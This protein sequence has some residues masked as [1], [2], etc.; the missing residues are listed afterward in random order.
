MTIPKFLG[1]HM[2]KANP[3]KDSAL[4]EGI[5]AQE[6]I[7]IIG[8]QI[9]DHLRR[10]HGADLDVAVGIK[11]GFGN[12]GAQQI[13]VHRKIERHGKA[14]ALPIL[15]VALFL[16]LIGEGNRLAIGVFNRCHRPRHRLRHAN[17]KRHRQRHGGEHMR[18]VIFARDGFVADHGPTGS[19]DDLHIQAVALIEAHGIGHD[20]GR[21]A[22]DGDEADF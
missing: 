3:I 13:V 9:G 2:N 14:E 7:N 21:R 11:P 17:A 1:Q 16:V 22:G 6:A 15:G 4:I 5:G 8:A 12:I 18:R 10:R 19:A 20:D